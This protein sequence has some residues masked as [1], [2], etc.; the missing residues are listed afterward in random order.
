MVTDQGEIQGA[1]PAPREMSSPPTQPMPASQPEELLLPSGQTPVDGGTTPPPS[2]GASN[3]FNLQPEY[4]AELT[5]PAGTPQY[6]ASRP[7]SPP[8]QPVYTRNT[9]KA[10]NR[11]SS[12][13]GQSVAGGDSG[14]IGPVG[15]DVQ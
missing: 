11:Q 1:M 14:L 13:Q 12:T 3:N 5:G 8:R 10:N 9:S 6:S 2:S 4:G 7:Y 15:Y